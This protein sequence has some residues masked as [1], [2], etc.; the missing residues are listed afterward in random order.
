MVADIVRHPEYATVERTILDGDGDLA[1]RFGAHHVG[2]SKKFRA[3]EKLSETCITFYV[4]QK[5][6]PAAGEAVPREVPLLYEDG[7][8][9][10]RIL[11][12]VC[13]L[14]GKP[15]G[16]SMRGGNA[17]IGADNEHGTVGLVFRRGNRDLFLTNAHVVTD[18]G[19]QPGPVRVEVPSG[20]IVEGIVTDIDN[21][22]AGVVRS[23]AAIVHVATGTIETGRFRGTELRLVGCGEIVNN[24]QRRFYYVASEFVHEAVW[25]GSVPGAAEIDID[26]HNLNY[27]GFHKLRLTVGRCRPGHSGAVVFCRSG[28]GLMAVGLLFGGIEDANEVWVFPVRRCLA[29]L[30]VDPDSL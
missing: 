21:L 26:G 19:Q 5:G 11:T 10:R 29:Q 28:A 30:G 2:V 13:E 18:P 3:G 9:G 14:G 17:V 22:L 25:L 23:D 1:A 27:A 15:R 6:Q 4:E 24:D 7:S 8:H 16:F 12:D 20:P